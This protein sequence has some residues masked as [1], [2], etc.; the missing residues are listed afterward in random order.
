MNLVKS[1]FERIQSQLIALTPS[2]K[3]LTASLLAIM[4]MT[5]FYWVHYAASPEFT[6]VLDQALS[7]ADAGQ[8]TDFL[9][10]RGYD[11]V[12]SND[13]V[14]VPSDRR[15]EAVAQLSYAQKLPQNTTDGFGLIMKDMNPF[16]SA[17]KTDVMWNH[18]KEITL[19]G[20][21]SRWPG[22]AGS[23]VVID[24]TMQRGI[25]LDDTIK[26]SASVN[27]RMRSGAKPEK[28]LA[29]AAV[30]LLT[31]AVAALD[32]SKVSV[33]VDGVPVNT[34]QDAGLGTADS[35][36]DLQREKENYLVSKIKNVL[37]FM[38]A[39]VLA[40][41]S[42]DVDN[43]SISQESTV[44][45]T[46]NSLYKPT[47]QQ[48]TSDE[49]D[50][51]EASSSEVGA[52]AN[53]QGSVAATSTPKTTNSKSEETDEYMLVPAQTMTKSTSAPGKMTVKAAAVWVPRS[54]FIAQYKQDNQTTKD[55]DPA[56]LQTIVNEQMASIRG[57]IKGCIGPLDDSAINIGL[58]DPVTSTDGPAAVAAAEP[59]MVSLALT[60][61]VKDI[62]VGALALV[63]L[64]M[65]SMMVK[66]SAPAP[67][68][69]AAP[70]H[71]DPV[72]LEAGEEVA[73]E[74]GEGNPLLDGMELDDDAV[75]TRQMV[76]QVSQMVK[77]NPD[78]AANLV[79]RWLN[80]T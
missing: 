47:K 11:V 52:G 5:L 67:V 26:P 23:S 38:N 16:D 63:S 75:K 58:Y 9:Q 46:K 71:V 27:I 19:A 42:V 59:T 62:A 12:V 36:M 57:A 10:S 79:K 74:A 66:K 51:S 78:A 43:Q 56:A 61:H 20:V 7:A 76:G 69:V 72:S 32:P 21:I 3:M 17:S 68:V 77:D 4:V 80:H 35:L 8:I 39:P 50:S 55:P 13:R 31:G 54:Y 29:Q 45:D 70:Q 41:V 65:V 14:M 30:K 37:A 60:D 22:V 2:Q 53:I 15:M 34:A 18:A 40:E 1:Q 24:T 6:P 28:Q 33:I 73:G 64:F 48:T 49:T 25:S 44:V